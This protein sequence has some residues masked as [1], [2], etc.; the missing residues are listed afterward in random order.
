M[1]QQEKQKKS[2]RI[3]R[4]VHAG[5]QHYTVVCTQDCIGIYGNTRVRTATYATDMSREESTKRFIMC[6][7]FH[8]KKPQRGEEQAKSEKQ[9]TTSIANRKLVLVEYYFDLPEA[10][11]TSKAISFSYSFTF[12][13]LEESSINRRRY[14][15]KQPTVSTI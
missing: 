13:L 10:V 4:E 8:T 5:F 1:K 11:V 6:L 15:Q 7:C 14:I 9:R 12:H 3:V 2:F